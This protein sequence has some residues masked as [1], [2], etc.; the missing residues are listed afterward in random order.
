MENQNQSA[1]NKLIGN[2]SEE[3]DNYSEESIYQQDDAFL[4]VWAKLTYIPVKTVFG[5]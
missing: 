2:Y 4:D 5:N 1:R 3:I